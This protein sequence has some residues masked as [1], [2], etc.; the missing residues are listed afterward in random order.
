MLARRQVENG[1]LTGKQPPLR[2]YLA[3]GSVTGCVSRNSIRDSS[4]FF[5]CDPF[6]PL[7]SE[8]AQKAAGAGGQVPR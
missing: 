1:S 4:S 2:D 3:A 6:K 5:A 8:V 7:G